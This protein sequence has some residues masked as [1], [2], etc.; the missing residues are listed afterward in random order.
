VQLKLSLH[1]YDAAT[2]VAHMEKLLAQHPESLFVHRAATITYLELHRYPEAE[3]QI[4]TATM[5]NG[6]DPDAKALLVRGIADPS[7]RATALQ[8][9]E[10]SPGNADFRGDAVV[11][12]FF[13]VQLGARDHAL[14]SIEDYAANGNST[15]PQ[16]LWKQV[17]DPIR[18]DP[19]F[20]AALKEM[21]L[22]YTPEDAGSR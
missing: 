7:Q 17:F 1:H 4:R 3:T 18:N 11:H 21:G 5:L 6:G 14:A 19:R 20:K 10:T 16:L 13:L 2:A 22:P 9:L 12:A 15:I 8:S